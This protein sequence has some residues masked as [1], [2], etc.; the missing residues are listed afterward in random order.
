M[1]ILYSHYGIEGKNGWGRSF[2]MAAA[3]AKLGHEVVFMTNRPELSFAQCRVRKIEGVQVISFPDFLPTSIKSKGFGLVSLAMKLVYAASRRFDMVVADCGHRP[4]GLPCRINRLLYGSFYVSEWWDFF[5]EEGY[6]TKKSLIFRACYGWIEKWAE[7]RDRQGADA[8]VV[9]SSL[10]KQRALS[11]GIRN[12][13]MIPG[14]ALTDVLKVFPL[15]SSKD[16][17]LTFGYIGMS[18]ADVVLIKPFIDAIGSA[19]F[20]GKVRFYAYG[21][22]LSG[23]TIRENKL[24]EIAVQKGWVDYLSDCECLKEVDIFLLV[25]EDTTTARAGWPNKLGDYLALGRPVLITPYGDLIKFVADNPEGFFSVSFSVDSIRDAIRQMLD[26]A[27]DLRSMGK[28][29]RRLAETISWEK[30]AE[31]L[32]DCYGSR[33][34][35]K[36]TERGEKEGT[37]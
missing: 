36:G 14:G 17:K 27:H 32:V 25:L 12:V 18:K 7:I 6:Y 10:M 34:T 8:V 21:D 2:Y 23:E 16:H 24:S 1:R 11:H 19:E 26:G 29:N 33:G 15:D 28:A 5:G 9:L 3:L 30:R 13:Y 20:A 37:D 22:Y 31:L 35:A 4:S